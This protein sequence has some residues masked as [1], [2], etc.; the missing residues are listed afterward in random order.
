M[1]NPYILTQVNG[2]KGDELLKFESVQNW[3]NSLDQIAK[4]RG[5]KG[6]SKTAKAMRLGRMWEFTNEGKLN[7]DELLKEAKENIDNAGKR[8][9]KYFEEKKS[10]WSHNSAITSLC[11]LRGFYTHNNLTFPKKWGVP[12]K[13]VSDVSK[14]DG[15]D[16]F[17]EYNAK[18]DE[19]EFK[20]SNMQ[21]FIQNLNFRDQTITLCLLSSGA[22][23][24]DLLNL[25]VGFV[26]DGRGK[27][28]DKKRFFWHG[29]RAK[30]AQPFK[31]F[32]SEE[33]T[34][35]LKRY[36]EQE[37]AEAKDSEPLFVGQSREYKFKKG[38]RKGEK[39]IVDERLTAQSLSSNFRDSAQ[40][41]GYAKEK[42][43]SSPFRPKRFRHLFR[44]ACAIA[45]IDNGFTMAFMGH[46]SSVSDSY[47]EQDPSI[48]EKMYVKIELFL[49]V[50]GINKSAVNEMS[51]E[52]TGLKDEVAVLSKGGEAITDR[53]T[54]LEEEVTDLKEKLECAVAY[55][56]TLREEVELK[57]KAEA[58]EDFHKLVEE[59]NKEH[60]IPKAT[61][62]TTTTSENTQD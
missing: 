31:T 39:V 56:W 11:Y 18:K 19:V 29:N 20:N 22:D 54:Q 10:K 42:N 49:T 15:K 12:K 5:K 23:A 17:F 14:R 47:L 6:L 45:Q 30:T 53:T 60:P 40:K 1:N 43:V 33:A 13:K 36:V 50:F 32:F 46:A 8:L 35:F 61:K 4:N 28:V 27:I 52:I 2:L 38:K 41:M 21:H 55:I 16:S 57:E 9:S 51:R 37:R 58:E 62:S 7:P 34:K 48:F 26:R 25:K 3:L 59:I 44:T 24:T